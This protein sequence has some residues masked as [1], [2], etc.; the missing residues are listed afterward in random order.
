[1]KEGRRGKCT[2]LVILA[3]RM[4]RLAN[5]D[6]YLNEVSISFPSEKEYRGTNQRNMVSMRE[7]VR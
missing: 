6:W 2:A 1:M 4:G 3:V 7:G 5:L